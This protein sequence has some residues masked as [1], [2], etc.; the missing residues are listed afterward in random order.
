M[1]EVNLGKKKGWKEGSER[2]PKKKD[3]DDYECKNGSE[4][5]EG[6]YSRCRM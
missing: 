2:R 5:I 6:L 1:K 4:G 3:V